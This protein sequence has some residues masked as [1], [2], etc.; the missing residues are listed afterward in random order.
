LKIPAYAQFHTISQ[1]VYLLPKLRN[2]GSTSIFIKRDHYEPELLA[3]K[4][5]VRPG[6]LVID[7]GG[8]FGVY[9]L[10]LA[11]YVGSSGQVITFE[12]G[13][14]SFSI[15][16]RNV[17]N[18]GMANIELHKIALSDVESKKVLYHIA[19]SP[20]NFS[21]G[22]NS[23]TDGESVQTIPLDLLMRNRNVEQL[24]FIKMDVE[25]YEKFVLDGAIKIISIAR[26]VIMFEV[27]NSALARAGLTELAPFEP[28]QKLDYKFFIFNDG[29]IAVT[30]PVQGNIFA[31]PVERL[32]D[33]QRLLRD[34]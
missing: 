9:T 5:F 4:E 20:V 24:S 25:G 19:G 22:G 21:L 2:F 8:S 1:K 32:S 33:Y 18:S 31:I 7:V 17:K 29:L 13:N 16:S 34:A 3:C 30:P 11:N 12:P 27:A 23:E 10:F 6:S 15:L 28:L 26:P 14:L